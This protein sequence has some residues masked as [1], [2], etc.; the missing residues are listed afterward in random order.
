MFSFAI[1]AE[2]SKETC[3]RPFLFYKKALYEVNGSG[4]QL[5]FNIF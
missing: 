1:D 4:L 3:Y 5:T 2:C